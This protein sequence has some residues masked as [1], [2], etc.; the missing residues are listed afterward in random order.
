[1]RQFLALLPM[2]MFMGAA[3]GSFT[4]VI[5]GLVS[6]A[7]FADLDFLDIWPAPASYGHIIIQGAFEGSNVGTIAGAISC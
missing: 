7:Y 3:A 1:M 2:G 6:P 4:N 5:N